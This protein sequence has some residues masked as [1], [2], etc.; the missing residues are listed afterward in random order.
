VVGYNHQNISFS[1]FELYFPLTPIFGISVLIKKE[2]PEILNREKKE[3]MSK[4]TM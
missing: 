3:K 1:A 2:F 4:A